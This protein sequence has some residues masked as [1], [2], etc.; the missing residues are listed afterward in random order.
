MRTVIWDLTSWE[1][2]KSFNYNIDTL[3]WCI[4]LKIWNV[5]TRTFCSLFCE[6][7]NCEHKFFDTRLTLV[8]TSVGGLLNINPIIRPI[9]HNLPDSNSV[10]ITNETHSHV[11]LIFSLFNNLHRSPDYHPSRLSIFRHSY[12]KLKKQNH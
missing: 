1:L 6:N 2:V 10:F 12:K 4:F 11:V 5:R 9:I 8:H 3:T 7:G